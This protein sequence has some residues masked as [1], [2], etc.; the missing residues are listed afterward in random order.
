MDL[1]FFATASELR[2]PRFLLAWKYFRNWLPLRN[3]PSWSL[4]SKTQA[5][6]DVREDAMRFIVSW[7]SFDLTSMGNLTDEGSSFQN[8]YRVNLR[9][10]AIGCIKQIEMKSSHVCAGTQ[11]RQGSLKSRED[12]QAS[13]F[14]QARLRKCYDFD[15]PDPDE[16]LQGELDD[17]KDLTLDE[18]SLKRGPNAAVK[19][20][21]Q[22][23]T[24]ACQVILSSYDFS[25]PAGVVRDQIK[26]ALSGK[27]VKC[28]HCQNKLDSK[29]LEL[30]KS[31]G[32]TV[33]EVF[34]FTPSEWEK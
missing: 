27:A 12:P 26:T 28:T 30:E 7:F 21:E 20:W 11:S 24:G 4:T 15:Y 2:W 10:H 23:K 34:V 8:G 33:P 14:G 3:C 32:E 1:P 31:W 29:V 13:K 19:T 18:R 25:N 22:A 17:F 6:N 16:I 9:N 5:C